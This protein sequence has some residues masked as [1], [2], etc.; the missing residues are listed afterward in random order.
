ML[1][2]PG[3]IEELEEL[4]EPEELEEHFSQEQISL[5]VIPIPNVMH[6]QHSSGRQGGLLHFD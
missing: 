5:A 2:L 4:E 6:L 1:L 3:S